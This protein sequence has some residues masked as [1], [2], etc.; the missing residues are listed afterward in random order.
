MKFRK[1]CAMALI[2]AMMAFMAVPTQAAP[3]SWAAEEVNRAI[4]LNLVPRSLQGS[5]TQPATRANFCAVAV[6]VYESIIREEIIERAEFRDTNDINIQ[7]MGGLGIVAGVGN[8]NFAP[9][10]PITREQAAV[11]IARMMYDLG[12]SFEGSS[13]TF[14]DN[15]NISSWAVEATA[16]VQA[17]GIMT[18]SNNM[19]MPKDT[20]TIEQSII[21]LLRLY[22]L[23]IEHS[24]RL[25]AA[26][27]DYSAEML[28]LLNAERARAGL[29]AFTTTPLLRA[30]A[31]IRSVELDISY[32]HTRP[33]GRGFYTVLDEL[34]ISFS[35]VGENV[36]RGKNLPP[37]TALN[38][39]LRSEGHRGNIINP[40][41]TQV[42]IG[43]HTDSAGVLYWVLLF[44]G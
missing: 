38:G 16:Q 5:Y 19:F 4:S 24:E 43:V 40:R 20:Y 1:I 32:S 10:S 3:S 31:I 34:G 21:T 25:T 9:N 28:G 7:K 22:D 36:F 27:C 33:D 18:G 14:A 17:A 6:N 41:F 23:A 8:N 30:A 37:Q 2:L 35:G 39:W 11:I 42:G 29:A 12:I 26:M 44:V 15:G 13:P